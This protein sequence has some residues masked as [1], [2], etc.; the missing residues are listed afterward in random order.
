MRRAGRLSFRVGDKIFENF[1]FMLE[2]RS[3]KETKFRR[4]DILE[5]GRKPAKVFRSV[6]GERPVLRLLQSRMIH[7]K[8]AFYVS[9][10][11]HFDSTNAFLLDA[12]KIQSS[13]NFHF[14]S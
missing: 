11:N 7:I 3:E 13:R 1:S 6:V 8:P 14:I 12:I 9:N 10:R 4:S 5:V 2:R